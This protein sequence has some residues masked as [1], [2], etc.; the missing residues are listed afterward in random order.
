MGRCRVTRRGET[1]G[2]VRDDKKEGRVT[3]GVQRERRRGCQGDKGEGA[4]ET[5]GARVTRRGGGGEV[6]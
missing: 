4:G 5:R 3:R 1:W 2:R 6:G